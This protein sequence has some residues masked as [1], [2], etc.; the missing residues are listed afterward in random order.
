M[1]TP[2]TLF[3]QLTLV[4]DW[5]CHRRQPIIR[6]VL[7]RANWPFDWGDQP[8]LQ[9]HGTGYSY[10]ADLYSP[11]NE[12]NALYELTT[13]HKTAITSALGTWSAVAN[14]NFTLTS[15]N[16]INVGDLRFGGYRLDGQQDRCVGVLSRTMLQSQATSGSAHA[17][18]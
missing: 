11:E 8:Q 12:Y 13:A 5:Q 6:Y 9:L 16:I 7:V 15:D 18:Q 3:D 1:P 14:L 10:F 17:N 4:A 2:L